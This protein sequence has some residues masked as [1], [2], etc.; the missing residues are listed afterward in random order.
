MIEFLFDIPATIEEAPYYEQC[1]QWITDLF[2]DNQ[3]EQ[4]QKEDENFATKIDDCSIDSSAT[5]S[6]IQCKFLEP[7]TSQGR[8]YDVTRHREL[9]KNPPPFMKWPP[10]PE[11][12]I[13]FSQNNFATHQPPTVAR[14]STMGTAHVCY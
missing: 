1:F 7:L 5:L 2:G 8:K 11:Q 3:D 4:Q 6:L 10:P 9:F 13:I 14:S 12:T